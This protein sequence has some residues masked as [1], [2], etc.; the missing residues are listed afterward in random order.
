M[1][2]EKKEKRRS[3][4]EG[5]VFQQANGTYQGWITLGK[6]PQTGKL[7]R[8]K[9]RGRTKALCQE[10][11][12][13]ARR[14]WEGGVTPEAS[15]PFG[16][17]LGKWLEEHVRPT[18][19]NAKTYRH[20]EITVR[21]HVKPSFLAKVRLK[22]MTPAQIE[23]WLQDEG[24]PT[25]R[26][27]KQKQSDDDCGHDNWRPGMAY[28]T[29]VRYKSN[30]NEAFQWAVKNR[31]VTINVAALAKVPE[32]QRNRRRSLTGDEVA[33][34]VKAAEGT[35]IE[36]LVLLGL[37]LGLRPGELL[38]LRWAN[39]DFGKFTLRVENSML[40]DEN[41]KSYEGDVK[42]SVAGG[43]AGGRTLELT[44]DLHRSLKR[45]QAAQ[46]VERLKAGDRWQDNDLVFSTS[47]GTHFANMR[48]VFEKVAA[49][50]P[51]DARFP[52][53]MRHTAASHMIDQGKSVEQ[54]ADI[55]GDRAETIHRYY[56]HKV[57]PVARGYF[58]LTKVVE[59]A[60]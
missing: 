35:R 32:V 57:R 18:S 17:F 29:L 25:C 34:L 56:R 54:V 7:V 28:D 14:D 49:V 58:D 52:Y 33:R 11:L 30:L 19:K 47:L 40:L 50:L 16:D 42:E 2:D 36:T 15:V 3:N 12:K 43:E 13:Q 9:R 51:K 10:A 55:L 39:I 41:G 26:D 38:G 27:C 45:H 6:D 46:A 23:K 53:V 4:G 44:P 1:K 37:T 60:R 5:S 24:T 21:V 31:W 22:D 20:K 8:A 59:Q 48:D